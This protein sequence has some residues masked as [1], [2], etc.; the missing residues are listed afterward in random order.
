MI[1]TEDTIVACSSPP[2]S[3]AVSCIRVSGKNCSELFK[4]IS[5]YEISHKEVSLC[6]IQLKEGFKEK[7]VLTSFVAP[8]SY[9]GEDVIGE[10]AH[11]GADVVKGIGSVVSGI[12]N[13]VK[14][15]SD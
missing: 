7:C 5:G 13:A 6:E 8:N 12:G 1:N 14:T 11:V 9:T 3:G 15:V 10:I 2:G 4:N